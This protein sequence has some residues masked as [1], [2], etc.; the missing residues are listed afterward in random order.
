M[1]LSKLKRG[2]VLPPTSLV[3]VS[4]GSIQLSTAIAKSSFDAV[5]PM[6]MLFLRMS[7][8][9]VMLFILWRPRPTEE[10]RAHYRLIILFGLALAAMNACFYYSLV[11]IPLGVAVTLEF[12]GPLGVALFNSRRRMDLLWVLLASVG[13]ILLSPFEGSALDPVGVALALLA[14]GFWA[15]YILLTARTGRVF[16]GSEGLTLGLATASVILLPWGLG[17]AGWALIQPNI[18]FVGF[19]VA[20]FSAVTYSLELE[21]LKRLPVNIFGVLMSLE[22]AIATLLGFI[23]LGEVLALREMTAVLLVTIAAIGASRFNKHHC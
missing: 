15:A 14:G 21:A 7:L 19:W 23:I 16:Q 4:M 9:A 17:S 13:I 1:K 2:V 8:A 3:L 6:A 20:L 22:P 5:G 18:L 10:I 12:V 11:Y